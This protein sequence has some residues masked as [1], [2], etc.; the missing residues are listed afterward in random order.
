M[1]RR[2][3][4]DA[5]GVISLDRSPRSVGRASASARAFFLDG[6]RQLSGAVAD[7]HSR[8][9]AVI[10]DALRIFAPTCLRTAGFR[11]PVGRATRLD[12]AMSR[13]SSPPGEYPVK[14]D[15]RRSTPIVQR[16][17]EAQAVIQD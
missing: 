13:H 9:Q 4:D 14:T 10:A 12:P 11:R 3:T 15:C 8:S 1:L 17:H 2:R 5:R 7:S 6:E 16:P